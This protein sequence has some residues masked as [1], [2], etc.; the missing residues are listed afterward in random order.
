MPSV[1]SLCDLICRR[2]IGGGEL[3]SCRRK[4]PKWLACRAHQRRAITAET[5]AIACSKQ[6]RAKTPLRGGDLQNRLPYILYR[7]R[8]SFG[9]LE[10]HCLPPGRASLPHERCGLPYRC[11]DSNGRNHSMLAGRFPARWIRGVQGFGKSLEME[12]RRQ[13]DR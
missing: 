5:R 10:I 7:H 8:E 6:T 4:T 13:K 3:L 1:W 9:C 12:N 2:R 11:C